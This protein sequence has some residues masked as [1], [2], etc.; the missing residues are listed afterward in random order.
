MQRG[1]G[2]IGLVLLLSCSGGAARAEA[3]HH[4]LWRVAGKH[5]V[6]YLLGSV[7]LLKPED[8]E[9][10]AVSLDAYRDAGLL[11]MELD[12]AGLTADTRPRST[13]RLRTLPRGQSLAKVLGP[14]LYAQ[15]QAQVLP[16]GINTELVS[17]FQ[18]WYGAM[19]ME[20][21]QL[22]RAGF[23]AE[24]GIDSQF[25]RLAR[26]DGKPIIELE[27]LREQLGFFARLSMTEQREYL[28]ASL[29]DAETFESDTADMIDAWKHGDTAAIE[30]SMR[31]QREESPVLF[32]RLI[33]E[34]N[35]RWLPRI[36][37]LLSRRQNALVV[38]GAMHLV[39]ADGLI[40]MLRAKGYDVQQ[41]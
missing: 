9:L 16:L 4:S 30:Q 15:Y 20:Q 39:S 21:V 7:H 33:V 22:A 11:M 28:R 31:E 12:P 6:V 36:V 32:R 40:E 19:V 2:I 1:L 3:G 10:P 34:R 29:K 37:A 5:N 27:T 23:D 26:I 13:L 14:D 35:R 18:P 17:R 25:A 8:S 38:V 41:Q 24:S